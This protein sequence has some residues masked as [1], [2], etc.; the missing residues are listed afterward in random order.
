MAEKVVKPL[1]GFDVIG[2]FIMSKNQNTASINP[3][4]D[5][6]GGGF[7]DID[8]D[9]LKNILNDEPI[10]PVIPPVEPVVPVEPVEPKVPKVPKEPKE[11]VVPPVEPTVPVVTTDDDK[12]YESE[13][14]SLLN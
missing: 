13:I 1:A 12:E 8:P 6:D 2:D 5:R 11:P 10:E 9:A 7:R 14:S 4:S 3:D